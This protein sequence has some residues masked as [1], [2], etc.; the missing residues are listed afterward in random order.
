MGNMT[1]LV[2]KIFESRPLVHVRSAVYI[3]NVKVQL[4]GL[5]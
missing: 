4:C 5:R 1:G 3:H 2:K